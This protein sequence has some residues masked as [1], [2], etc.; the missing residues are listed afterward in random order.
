MGSG[1]EFGAGMT[2]REVEEYVNRD[3]AIGE[4]LRI[5]GFFEKS[6][7]FWKE[8]LNQGRKRFKYGMKRGF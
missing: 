3:A 5:L 2:L 8:K 6:S 4:Y 7:R 1:G